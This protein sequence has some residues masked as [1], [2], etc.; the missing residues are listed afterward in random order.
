VRKLGT[1]GWAI[2]LIAMT[3][4]VSLML[5]RT[6]M[7]MILMVMVAV[8]ASMTL[9]H[10]AMAAA[11]AAHDHAQL[12]VEHEVEDAACTQDC[13]VPSHSIPACCGMGLCL[14]GLPV[15]PQAEQYPPQRNATG[16]LDCGLLPR[17]FVGRID[18]PP[19]ISDRD[20]L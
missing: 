8:V 4:S 9:H 19:K 1:A 10:G 13:S 7:R 5:I 14:S 15:T 17:S 12:H 16:V 6:Q 2:G 3:A 20:E 18:R 11:P